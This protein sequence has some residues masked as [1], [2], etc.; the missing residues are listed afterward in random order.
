MPALISLSEIRQGLAGQEFVFFYQPIYS[1]VTGEICGAEALLRWRRSDDTLVMP[2][3]FIPQA[4]ASGLIL[5]IT[6]AMYP[7]LIDDLAAITALDSTL[8]AYLNLTAKDLENPALIGS[9]AADLAAKGIKPHNLGIEIVESVLMPPNEAIRKSIFDFAAAGM[10]IV[11]DDFSAGNTTLNYL[12][13]LP[14]SAIKLSMNIVNRAPLSQ[15]DFRVLRH[16]VSMGHQLRLN[17]IAEGLENEELYELILSTGCSAAQGYHLSYPL[18]LSEFL[19]LLK[20]KPRRENYPFGL[21][22]LA[23]IDHVDFRRDVIRE[24]LIIYGSHDEEVRKRAIA[25]LPYLQP[26]ASL[27][28]EWYYGAGQQWLGTS[29]YRALEN[30]H[31][32]F[33]QTAQTLLR[34]AQAHAEWNQVELLIDQLAEQSQEILGY[35]QRFALRGIKHHYA[36]K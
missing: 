5:E 20:Q 22:Y 30:I 36:A 23:Q 1:L 16:L 18:P 28:G 31:L 8:T 6:Q 12:S 10:P 26:E 13:Q 27:M 25:R 19:A 9:I 14:L 34:A 35:L 7:R 24:A 32:E 2:A 33:H 11:L 15:M 17:V 21:E 4:A 29:E 3:D